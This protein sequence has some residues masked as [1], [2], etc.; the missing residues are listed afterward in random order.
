ME[1]PE[2]KQKYIMEL[3][4][5]DKSLVTNGSQSSSP[6]RGTRTIDP[7]IHV[8]DVLHTIAAEVSIRSVGADLRFLSLSLSLSSSNDPSL[9]IRTVCLH[10]Y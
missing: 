1:L 4:G 7:D 8:S 6:A 9:G 3:S 2:W 10:P 5:M